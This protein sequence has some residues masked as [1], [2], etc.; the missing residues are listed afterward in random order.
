MRA[1]WS[2]LRSESLRATYLSTKARLLLAQK[3]WTDVGPRALDKTRLLAVAVCLGFV[4][5]GWMS[6]IL[7]VRWARAH[8][9]AAIEHAQALHKTSQA[10]L[11]GLLDA[12]NEV[13]TS[14][15]QPEPGARLPYQ[16]L[17]DVCAGL[18]NQLIPLTLKRPDEKKLLPELSAA[19][20]DLLDAINHLQ[21]VASTGASPGD[22]QEWLIQAQKA[23]ANVRLNLAKLEEAEQN[24]ARPNPESEPGNRLASGDVVHLSSADAIRRISGFGVLCQNDVPRYSAIGTAAIAASQL[25]APAWSGARSGA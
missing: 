21:D 15:S 1:W 8:D 25:S 18:I 5:Q 13:N 14:L 19:T 20:Q 6:V 12:E 2:H 24:R 4:I 10:L 22:S 9:Q 7:A 11:V 23:I 16:A 3:R 17:Q